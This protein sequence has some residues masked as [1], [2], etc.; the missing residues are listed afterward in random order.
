MSDIGR[1]Y[2]VKQRLNDYV[3]AAI[4][5]NVFNDWK[6]DIQY[7]GTWPT[8]TIRIP[9]FGLMNENYGRKTPEGGSWAFYEFTIFI[10]NKLDDQ[11]GEGVPDS[12]ESYDD[13][14][15]VIDY[16][17]SIRGNET[18]KSTYGIYWIDNLGIYVETSKRPKNVGTIS[19]RGRIRA[20]WI[21]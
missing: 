13:A 17:L 6:I 2:T 16:L 15:S 1:I 8:S 5:G 3:E 14:E 11:Y 10:H 7:L 20:K 18:E 12:Y 4:G 21:D 9:S 19:V